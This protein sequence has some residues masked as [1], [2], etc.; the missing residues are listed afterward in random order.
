M[1]ESRTCLLIYAIF[2]KLHLENSKNISISADNNSSDI[3]RFVNSEVDRLVSKRLLLDGKVSPKIKRKT[4]ETL[5]NG[6]QGM[7]RWV[8]MSLETLKRIKFLPDFKKAL[9]Q[10][11]SE[12]AGLYDIIHSQIEQTEPYGQKVAIRTLNWLLCA[13]R[14]L[15][16]EELIAAVYILEDDTSSDSD[17]DPEFR[18]EASPKDDILRLCRNLIVFD[19]EQEIFRF[20]HQSVREY[21]IKLSRYTIEEQ[22]AF[23]TER[24]LEI[25]LTKSLQDPITWQEKQQNAVLEPYAEIYW[26]VHYKYAENS[27]SVRLKNMIFLFT[28]QIRGTSPPYGEWRSDILQKYGH[29]NY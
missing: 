3:A 20:A 4:I 18:S 28:D 13:Q 25:Y 5:I 2:E 21:L 27:T 11:P 10:L 22:H 14:L 15:S 17:E 16:A 8:E 7:F 23:A 12:L 19:S 29:D 26:P 9:G 24:C 6:A 1:V